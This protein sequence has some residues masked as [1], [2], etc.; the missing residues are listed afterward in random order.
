MSNFAIIAVCLII[1]YLFKTFKLVEKGDYKVINKW[2]IFVGLPAVALRYIPQIDWQ[3]N[4]LFTAILPIL[5]F[6]FSYLFFNVLNKF[7]DFSQRTKNTLIIVSGLSNTSFVGF[8]L[9]ISFFGEEQLKVGIVSD[10][11]T[12]F[13]LSTL[14]VLLA[15]SSRNLFKSPTDKYKFIVKRI[16]TFPP[17]IACIIALLFS[18]FLAN[19]QFEGFFS[20]LAATVSPMALFSIGM[21]L[22]FQN[23]WKEIRAISFSIIYKLLLAPALCTL[24]AV[25]F[26]LHGVFFQVSIFE[27]AMPSLVAS[28]MIIEKFGL[29]VKLANTIIGISIIIGL[30]S[31]FLWHSVIITLL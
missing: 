11:V 21:Q 10:Q 20:M 16:F 30:L 19:E 9:I 29:N 22:N 7:I 17:L 8:P 18:N 5:I 3:L 24:I 15:A 6:A 1:G 25:Y 27:M 14:G 28:S 23:V 2:V 31:S 12:F 13:T 4:Y 26:K